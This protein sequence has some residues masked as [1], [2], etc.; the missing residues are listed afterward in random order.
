MKNLNYF[1]KSLF[2][3]GKMKI[4]TSQNITID[5][6]YQPKCN[7]NINLNKNGFRKETDRLKSFQS[8]LL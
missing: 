4:N 6:E 2:E 5:I 7:V 8:Y 3:L 1:P